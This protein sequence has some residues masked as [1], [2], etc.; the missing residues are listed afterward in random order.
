MPRYHRPPML[1][2]TT[3]HWPRVVCLWLCGVVAAMQ[4]AK[5]SFAFAALQQWY[6]L[7]AAQMGIILST[8]GLTGL[9]FGVTMG[10]YAH[11]IGYRRLLL[12]GLALGAVLATLQSLML[13]P[14][15]LWVTR[16]LEGVSHLAV[17]VAAP[18]LIA[19]SCAPRQRSV[20]MGLWSTFV[21]VAFAITGAFGPAVLSGLGLSGLLGLHALGML[22]MLGWAAVMLPADPDAMGAGNWPRWHA[23]PRHHVQIYTRWETALPGLCFFCYT[24]MAV[25]LLTFLP[26]QA[27]AGKPWLAV[28]LPLMG[29]SGT[30]SAGWLAQAWVTPLWLVRLAFVGVGLAGLGLWGCAALGLDQAPA[31]LILM[32]LAGLAGG[33]AFSLIPYLS[34]ESLVQS[35]ANGAVAQ[36]GNLG[37]TLGPPLFAATLA[38]WGVAGLALPVLALALLGIGVASWGA[39]QRFHQTE[40]ASK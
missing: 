34:H 31:A 8:V 29:I 37:S 1:I 12:T 9:A 7:S 15:W 11:A 18:T 36:M 23:V 20:A 17:V 22:V 5:L 28:M 2:P 3:T 40:P 14:L 16:V 32:Y 33:S 21:G 6:A 19:V 13:P 4:F 26:Q 39:R 25:A 10:L 24:G 27:G 35:R 38:A 30:F